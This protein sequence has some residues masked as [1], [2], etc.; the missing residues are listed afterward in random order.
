MKAVFVDTS[1]WYPLADGA[2]P[3]HQA[4][5][6]ALRVRVRRGV[7]VVTSNLVVAESHALLLRRVG[8]E[9]ALAFLEAV[10]RPPNRIEHVTPEREDTAVDS[11]IR[12]FADQDFSLADATSFAIMSELGI[13]EALTLDRHFATAGF[14]M[15]PATT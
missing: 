9:V 2:H 13:E 10:R 4:L 15:I 5:V 7:A 3:D 11:W 1:A 14:I 12:R 8:R 6:E